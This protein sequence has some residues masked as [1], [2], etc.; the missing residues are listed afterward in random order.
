[1]EPD[2]ENL[3]YGEDSVHLPAD[4]NEPL[5]FEDALD[6]VVSGL[7]IEAVTVHTQLLR[8]TNRARKDVPLQQTSMS[9]FPSVSSTQHRKTRTHRLSHLGYVLV[10]GS[11]E[12]L[13]LHRRVRHMPLAEQL[14]HGHSTITQLN[15]QVLP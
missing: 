1:M 5:I 11:S 3:P 6:A 13:C 8:I 15:C 2:E 4:L 7:R 10:K 14:Q 12:K 9:V